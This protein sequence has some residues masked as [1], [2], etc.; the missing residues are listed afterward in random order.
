MRYPALLLF[1]LL[2]PLA[3]AAASAPRASSAAD[4]GRLSLAWDAHEAGLFEEALGYLADI[5]VSSEV[6]SDAAWLRAECLYDLGRYGEAVKALEGVVLIRE[7]ERREFLTDVFWRWAWEATY[8]G[9]WAEAVRVLDRGLELVPGEGSLEALREASRFRGEVARAVAAREERL[10]SGE[11]VSVRPASSPPRGADWVRAHPW[12]EESPWLPEVAV[13][14]WMPGL[15]D[16][17]QGA[18]E[19]L[20]ISVPQAALTRAVGA[21]AARRGLGFAEDPTGYRLTRG[22]EAVRLRPAEWR[23]RAGVE[24]LGAAGAA[25]F[26]VARAEEDLSSREEVSR[27]VDENRAEL[28]L[29]REEGLLVL[30]NPETGRTFELRPEEWSDLLGAEPDE[31]SEFWSDLRAELAR[32]PAPFRCFCGRPVTLRETLVADPSGLVV[33]ELGRGYATAAVAL[34]PLHHQRVT[35]NLARQWGVGAQ[36]VRDRASADALEQAWEFRFARGETDGFAYLVLDGEGVSSLA[37]SPEFLAGALESVDG[38]GACARSVRVRALT[39][40][41]LLVTDAAVPERVG[42]AAA[43]RSL[44]VLGRRGHRSERVDYRTT[45]SLPARGTGRFRVSLAE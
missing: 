12:G 10:V 8:R 5:P 11:R 43:S 17:L 29:R 33:L 25:L 41:A 9:G 21:A 16:R 14:D 40:S 31:W 7:G 35:E 26:A 3:S 6:G 24:G 13:D 22:K 2:A 23:F 27:W 34:C 45:L 1:L 4:R 19:A 36:E 28:D 44:L 30:R 20:W 39:D 37:R 32:P 42:D 18:G 38:A 15:A